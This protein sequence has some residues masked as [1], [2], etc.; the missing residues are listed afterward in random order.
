[1][2]INKIENGRSQ[3]NSTKLRRGLLAGSAIAIAFTATPQIA[4]AQDAEG[5]EERIIVTGSRI[6]RDGNDAPTPVSVITKAEIDA[7]A[8]ASITDFVNTLPAVAGSQTAQTN[9][10]S[11]SSSNSGIS[12]LNLR[13]M[14][15][16]RTLVL[17]DGRRSVPSSTAGL[18]DI[19]TFPQSLIER[20]DVVTGGASAAY[21]SDAVS[22]VVNFILD[23]DYEGVK[24]SYQY[25]I[26]TYG[27]TPNHKIELA[28][29]TSLLDD[30]LHVIGAFEWFKQ[31]GV[32]TL[33]RDWN[34]SR[35]F[36][37]NNPYYVEGN[38]EP[39]R[40]WGS[41]IGESILAPG[42]LITS[43]PFMGTYFGA[44]GLNGEASVNQF[45]YGAT[46]GRWMIGGDYDLD[47]SHFGSNSLSP[48]E[49]RIGAFGRIGFEVTPNIE[50]FAQVSWNKYENTSYYQQ[51][52]ASFT[53]QLDNPF[54][55][56]DFVDMVNAYN[57][58]NPGSEVTSFSVGTSTAGIP[59]AGANNS[60]TVE[61][62]L[63]GAEGDAG[64]L[65]G[66]AW[67]VSYQYG[68]ADLDQYLTNTFNWNRFYS[69]LDAVD[70][71][72]GNA[73][74]RDMTLFAD[75]VPLNLIG[76]GGVTPEALEFLFAEAPER[77]QIITQEV[78]AFNVIADNILDLWAGPIALGIG[79]EWRRE[80]VESILDPGQYDTSLAQ[81]SR[82]WLYGNYKNDNGAYNVKEAYIEALVPLFDGADFNG[83]FRI[84]DYSS[85]G[86][87]NTWKAGLTWEI[88][89]SIKVRGTVSRDIR[90]G[91]LDDQFS[92]GTARTNA[93]SRPLLD[94]SGDVSDQFVQ[95]QTGN[96]N[97]APEKALTYGF[98]AIFT[99]EF[100]PGFSFA[101]DYWNID[102][103]D[104][105]SS[106]SAENTVLFCFEQ[107]V[108]EQCLNIVYTDSP[109]VRYATPR[110]AD[111]DTI[112]LPKF[113]FAGQQASGIDFEANYRTPV[114][115]GD[116]SLRAV[117]TYYIENVTDTGVSFPTDA[118]GS[119][120]LPELQYRFSAGYALD[121]FNA[122]LVARGFSAGVIDNNYVECTSGCPLSTPE[123][124]T[125]NNN[126]L[127]GAIYFDT[128]FSYSFEVGAVRA[129]AIFAIK[130]LLDRDP[131]IFGQGSTGGNNVAA[132]PQ[133]AR[134]LYDTL[135]RTFRLGVS[136]EY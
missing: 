13:Q 132:Y 28:A 77:S 27:D 75:C 128:N 22:G 62:Y 118:A 14:G 24:G 21:G 9:S 43:G 113:N 17:L 134:E 39:E 90:A 72:F 80:E 119:R 82:G 20:V 126:K 52:P 112:F 94:G 121:A 37:V 122:V 96:P 130:N 114:G 106:L 4:L 81:Y 127:E 93:I 87:V 36:L 18:V 105:I 103:T 100:A 46:T 109:D 47:D 7:E 42:G 2:Q 57:T 115:P 107:N 135:G 74:C 136:F 91:N 26:T 32:D 59:S 76:I 99:P 45:A 33:N 124:R 98:G 92:S 108:A 16:N 83:A 12:A 120:D 129:K 70:D 125:V 6:V 44:Q 58:A 73:V 41:G 79:G 60:R 97:I 69:A 31:T 10:G 5:I 101:V 51:T 117:A 89:P 19:N 56:T 11:L 133:T 1:M 54:L 111:I 110:D 48:H 104:A 68:R 30:R 64:I 50:L 85:S 63:V 67:D 123:A 34:D 38:G 35:T 49:E 15:S 29:G 40:Y 61:R 116:L 8:P 95:A 65:G 53:A 78:A 23:R 66:L 84:T 86:S 25:G 3:L 88:N 71:G 55:P 131:Y 102:L